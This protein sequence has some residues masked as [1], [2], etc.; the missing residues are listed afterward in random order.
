MES[1]SSHMVHRRGGG[2]EMTSEERTAAI[3]VK[4]DEM[5]QTQKEMIDIERKHDRLTLHVRELSQQ[6]RALEREENEAQIRAAFD[7]Q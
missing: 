7:A 6:I 3:K 1:D 4:Q 5:K 2:G